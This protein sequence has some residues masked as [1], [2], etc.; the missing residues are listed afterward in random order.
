MVAFN[1]A[2]DLP[3]SIDTVEKLAIWTA[4]VLNH[5]YPAATIVEGAGNASNQATAAPFQVTTND[6]PNWIYI[7]RVSLQLSSN[8]Q[9][10]NTKIWAN[11]QPIGNAAI[12]TEFKS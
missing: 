6:P 3:P 12:P 2:T 11:A 9:R 7:G 8:W 5:L 1:A 4:T 10:G